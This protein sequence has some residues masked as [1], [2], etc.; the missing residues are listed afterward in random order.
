MKTESE[1]KSAFRKSVRRYKGFSMALAAP[2]ISG[3]PD[4]FV[5]MPDYMPIL[6][7]AKWLGEITR[8][9]FSRKI[10]FT[11]LQL[12]WIGECHSVNP[13]TAMGLVGC[14]YKDKIHAIL[15]AHGT[16]QFYQLSSCF[17]TDCSYSILS[18]ETKVFDVPAMFSKVPIPRLER[19]K[20]LDQLGD[21]FCARNKN[22][23]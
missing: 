11:P 6:F 14:I 19:K 20:Y 16:P 9:K 4:I 15:V 17:L 12:L 7:E 8:E 21:T 3:I 2:M 18:A 1:F 10:Q 22:L 5:V 23:G 13:Y